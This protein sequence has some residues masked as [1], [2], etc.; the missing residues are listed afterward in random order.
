MARPGWSI[1]EAM[2]EHFPRGSFHPEG[3]SLVE[4]SGQ[5]EM[6]DPLL[7]GFHQ[8]NPDCNQS[9]ARWLFCPGPNACVFR[10]PLSF[11]LSSGL[12]ILK[13]GTLKY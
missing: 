3:W 7:F 4:Q 5:K 10:T 8:V 12:R 9:F 13:I 11:P 6:A 2:E 1:A